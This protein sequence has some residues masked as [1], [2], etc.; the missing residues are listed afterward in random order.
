MPASRTERTQMTASATARPP[1][2]TDTDGQPAVTRC[3]QCGGTNTTTG[4][5]CDQCTRGLLAGQFAF[6]HRCEHCGQPTDIA[7]RYCSR[8]LPSGPGAARAARQQDDE[9][10]VPAGYAEHDASRYP[11]KVGSISW[12]LLGD[13]YTVTWAPA[14]AGCSLTLNRHGPRGEHAAYRGTGPTMQRAWDEVRVQLGHAEPQPAASITREAPG[15]ARGSDCLYRVVQYYDSWPF[16]HDSRIPR[17]SKSRR[18]TD[19]F[20]TLGPVKDR[21][22]R[23]NGLARYRLR[24]GGDW[25]AF[26]AIAEQLTDD[27]WQPIDV[28]LLQEHPAVATDA[29]ARALTA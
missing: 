2:A 20:R 9:S 18:R 12:Y 6:P 27:G 8:C 23:A 24:N 7:G 21:L 5:I 29:A 11:A 4:T 3:Q 15:P 17:G 13:G 14:P 26:V 1:A 22:A 28:D 25:A 19:T 10:E 16:H